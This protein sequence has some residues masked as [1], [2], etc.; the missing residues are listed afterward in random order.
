MIIQYYGD[1]CFKITTKPEG[2]ATEDVVIWTDPL[3]KGA[4]FRN[5]VGDPDILILSHNT[6]DID[7]KSEK[8]T[9]LDM[10]GEFAAR[11]VTISGYSTLTSEK[12]PDFN[13]AFILDSEGMQ[14]GYLG[15]LGEEPKPEVLDKFSGIDV[16]FVP[17]ENPSGWDVKTATNVVKKIEPKVIILM[18]F[19][20]KG[21]S[22][23]GLAEP[24]GLVD[25]LGG[26]AESQSKLNIKKKDIE[27]DFMRV[28]ILEKGS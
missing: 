10:P 28:V 3:P 20:Q 5:P 25:S 9:V 1:F 6:E 23:K 12:T 4:G 7:I 14:I 17:V 19:A 27:A 8:T 21:L 26:N 16:L 18:H 24:K 13:T 11:G 22:I 2:R 15:S